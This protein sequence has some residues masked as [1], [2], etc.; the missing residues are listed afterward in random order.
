MIHFVTAAEIE[1]LFPPT[2]DT[3][4]Q[5]LQLIQA[6]HP[7]LNYGITGNTSETI[8]FQEYQGIPI[9]LN[10]RPISADGL[11]KHDAEKE[12]SMPFDLTR[13]PLVRLTILERSEG[14][15]V[16]L[17]VNHSLGDDYPPPLCC[18][19]L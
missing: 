18:A 19:S 14:C 7:A 9:P 13:A 5:A 4:R 11:W 2:K 8:H 12:L 3:W 1:T 15:V 6:K 10:I 16:L 17:T